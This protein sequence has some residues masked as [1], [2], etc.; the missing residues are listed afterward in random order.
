MNRIWERSR[1]KG[2]ALLLLLAIADHA[3]DDGGGAYPSVPALARK[4]RMPVRSTQRLIQK[5]VS[6]GELEVSTGGGPRGTHLYKINLKALERGDKLSGVRGV[7][8]SGV[9]GDNLS[10]EGVTNSTHGGDK[11]GAEGVTPVTHESSC[12]EGT[13]MEP[14]CSSS[15]QAEPQEIA[16]AA[17]PFD[18]PHKSIFSF[19]TVEDFVK[20]QKPHSTNPGGLARMIWRSGAED[21]AIGQ[22]LLAKKE[23]RRREEQSA[24]EPQ[25]AADFSMDAWVDD[26]IANNWIP[27]LENEREQ[28]EERGGPKFD[29]E[30]KVVAYF[31]KPAASDAA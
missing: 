26:L 11:S 12:K 31:N 18:D 9:R 25:I 29:W 19:Y 30:R 4:I 23:R 1:N 5:L 28:I 24:T 2:A 7:K 22:W 20:D 27:Q 3:H 8:L 10:G 13:V 21:S 15:R 16:A 6:T 14:S 17:N